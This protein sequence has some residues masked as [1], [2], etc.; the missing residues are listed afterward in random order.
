MK[1]LFKS[2]LWLL[3]L[4]PLEFIALATDYYMH[5]MLGYVPF[6]IVAIFIGFSIDRS[7]LANNWYLLLSRFI[8]IGLSW[9]CIQCFINIDASDAYF[10]PLS[11]E[12]LSLLL[13]VIWFITLAISYWFIHE[14]NSRHQ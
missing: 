3:A 7:G 1:K 2:L 12:S 14:L 13:G 10:K 5:T 8:G 11:V 9:L 4:L 6:V